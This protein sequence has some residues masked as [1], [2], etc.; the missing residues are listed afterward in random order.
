MSPCKSA[1]CD[2]PREQGK[3]VGCLLIPGLSRAL[4]GLLLTRILKGAHS[5]P[6][7]PGTEAGPCCSTCLLKFCLA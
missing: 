7:S 3:A 4:V 6:V 2:Y 1:L 5:L